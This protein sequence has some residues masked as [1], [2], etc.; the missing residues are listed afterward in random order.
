MVELVRGIRTCIWSP[1]CYCSNT[2]LSVRDSAKYGFQLLVLIC[3]NC[4]DTP[5]FHWVREVFF[6]LFYHTVEFFIYLWVFCCF[7]ISV[8]ACI[9]S[10][11]IEWLKSNFIFGF[12]PICLNLFYSPYCTQTSILN[13][14]EFF[15]RFCKIY[16][17]YFNSKQLSIFD[18]EF[19]F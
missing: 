3:H 10:K 15:A 8:L 7:Q 17:K 11:I 13:Y 4:G 14:L 2:L 5:C 1:W 12:I 9:G 19:L 16:C 6:I 18:F